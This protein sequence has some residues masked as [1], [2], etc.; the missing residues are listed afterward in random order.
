M[1]FKLLAAMDI[2]A[3]AHEG[4]V[5]KYTG[6]PYLTHPF[7]VAGLVRSVTDDEDMVAAA[8]LHDVVEDSDVPLSLIR[9]L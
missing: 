3:R 4:Q 1:E 5:R 2:A 6:E 8:I 7:A 9:E